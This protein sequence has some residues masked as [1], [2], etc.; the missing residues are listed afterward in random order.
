MSKKIL[1]F[2]A[3][4]DDETIGCGGT[5]AKWSSEGSLVEVCFMTDGATGVEQNTS[6]SNITL[7]RNKEANTACKILGVSKIHFLGLACQEVTN[8]KDTFHKVVSLIR[9]I[10]PD[11]VITHDQI[12]KHRDHKNTSLI[13]EESC[14]KSSENILEELGPPHVVPLVMSCEI[15]D[16]FEKPDYV[17]DISKYY[18][19]KCSAMSVY[20]TQRGVIP[21]IEEYL[22][23][24]TKVRGNS[25]GPGKRAEAFKKIG[26]RPL[27]L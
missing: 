9:R 27:E 22:D 10:R 1:I 24:I 21:G 17:V 11:I 5:I 6:I 3:H 2:V 4:Q 8:N 26:N 16:P 7:E 18:D 14:W 12:C 19:I 23:G 20:T 25:I 15:L 13:V